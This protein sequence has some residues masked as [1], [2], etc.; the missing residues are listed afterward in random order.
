MW[1]LLA[2]NEIAFK[3]DANKTSLT[4]VISYNILKLSE[5]V[6][7]YAKLLKEICYI[8]LQNEIELENEYNLLNPLNNYNELSNDE[9]MKIHA[10]QV[11]SKIM[12]RFNSN[13]FNNS[14]EKIDLFEWNELINSNNIE[15]LEYMN[16]KGGLGLFSKVSMNCNQIIYE[17]NP[18]ISFC[19]TQIEYI[20]NNIKYINKLSQKCSYCHRNILLSMNRRLETYKYTGIHCNNCNE[21]YCCIECKLLAN[22]LYHL[23]ICNTK[24]N[25]IVP[26]N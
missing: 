18:L 9:S 12:Y 13:Y 24:Y 10:S 11:Q 14:K 17:E 3:I 4:Y 8:T 6:I 21:L 2:N 19:I 7:F 20:I 15:I 26:I 16:G 25:I 5:N 1:Q 22:N 23:G